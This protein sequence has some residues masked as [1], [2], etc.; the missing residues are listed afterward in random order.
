MSKISRGRID[1][2]KRLVEISQ[3]KGTL[4]QSFGFYS[5]SKHCLSFSEAIFLSNQRLFEFENS[6]VDLITLLKTEGLFSLLCNYN[7]LKN[8]IKSFPIDNLS[9]KFSLNS[10]SRV[11]KDE[12][13]NL[14]CLVDSDS[15]VFD[16]LENV[17]SDEFY[18][19]LCLP[20]SF[21]FY[22]I[23]KI[24]SNRLKNLHQS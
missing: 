15:N 3:E 16:I 19:S 14:C 21:T 22:Q 10:K 12:N 23:N 2:D 5:N 13:S 20:Q 9:L 18:T 4:I 17:K 8:N 6:K 24:D 7:L 1:L 11:C